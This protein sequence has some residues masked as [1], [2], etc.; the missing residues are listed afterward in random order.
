[1]ALAKDFFSLVS[2]TKGLVIAFGIL[3]L[4]IVLYLVPVAFDF[5][6]QIHTYD[7]NWRTLKNATSDPYHFIRWMPVTKLQIKGAEMITG[8]NFC[9]TGDQD[10]TLSFPDNAQ[11]YYIKNLKVAGAAEFRVKLTQENL[12]TEGTKIG[13]PEIYLTIDLLGKANQRGISFRVINGDSDTDSLCF[14]KGDDSVT[15]QGRDIKI[16]GKSIEFFA[17]RTDNYHRDCG[18]REV[19]A[20]PHLLVSPGSMRF[21]SGKTEVKS[22]ILLGK[23][24]PTYF[25]EDTKPVRISEDEYLILGRPGIKRLLGLTL[26]PPEYE[27]GKIKKKGCL[28]AVI[29]G[30]T[31]SIKIGKSF[32]TTASVCRFN[33]LGKLLNRYFTPEE[34]IKL[35]YLDIAALFGLVTFYIQRRLWGKR[36]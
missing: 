10:R 5:E 2:R 8:V 14:F 33:L 4:P 30:Q 16:Y 23:L 29:E 27:K 21:E 6:G 32:A 17:T 11:L 28:V 1:M 13:N 31:D 9:S 24:T 3:L 25:T 18:N 7:L 22:T 34:I 12:S 26:S 19:F 20:F 36:V 35:I 15:I